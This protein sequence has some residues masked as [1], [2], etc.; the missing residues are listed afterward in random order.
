MD[1]DKRENINVLI[2][3]DNEVNAL[4][5]SNMLSLFKIYVDE[6][7]SGKSAIKMSAIKKYDIIFVDHVMPEMNGLETTINIRKFCKDMNE[8]AIYA[9]T[10]NI[11]AEKQKLYLAAGANNIYEK[12]LELIDLVSILKNRFPHES[13]NITQLEED[14]VHLNSEQE[15]IK[16]ILETVQEIDFE[17]GMKYAIGNPTHYVQVLRVSLKDLHICIN[18][19]NAS[20]KKGMLEDMRISIHNLKS[21][22][23]NIGAKGLSEESLFM[24]TMIDTSDSD[25]IFLHLSYYINHIKEFYIKLEKAIRKY[26][27]IKLPLR[28]EQEKEYLP[29]SGEEYENCLLNTI[30]YIKRFE[31]DFIINELGKLINAEKTDIKKEYNKALEEIRVFNYDKALERILKI[32]DKKMKR[33]N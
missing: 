13:L 28:L 12:P 16:K 32:K 31:Y 22:F 7:D 33:S 25:T 15:L 14:A 1:N 2:I 19:I 17:I 26:E 11:T 9:L 5:L 4:V 8:T 6:T 18:N 10:S 20:K 29:L 21:V 30:Y 27:A 24:E 23:S 3:D